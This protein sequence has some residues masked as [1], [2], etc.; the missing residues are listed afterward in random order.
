MELNN[1]RG[2][3]SQAA[4]ALT[5]W[6]LGASLLGMTL[7][8]TSAQAITITVRDATGAPFST[9][10]GG[11]RYTIEEDNTF[12]VVPDVTGLSGL[13]GD[14]TLSLGLHKSYMK[15][16]KVGRTTTNSVDWTP[17]DSTKR[18]FISVTPLNPEFTAAVPSGYTSSGAPIRPIGGAFQDVVVPLN[19]IPF[20]TAQISVL[21]FEDT[22]INGAP[23]APGSQERGLCGFEVQLFEAGGTYG[24]SG[25]RVGTD[26][27]GNWLGTEYGGGD[28]SNIVK[29]GSFQQFADANGVVRIKN[30]AP[31]KYTVY[32]V[33]PPDMPSRD[34]CNLGDAARTPIWVRGP[35]TAAQQLALQPGQ[36]VW[37]SSFELP[38][39]ASEGI[40]KKWHQTS[41][42]EGT[43]GVDAWVKSGEPTFF[44]EFGPPGHHVFIG[45]TRRFKD[46]AALTGSASVTGTVKSTHMSRPPTIRFHS[47]AP[48][49]AC[50]IGINAV[51]P[52]AGLGTGVYANACNPDGS[53]S[54]TNLVAGQRY[55]LVV[56]D[57]PLDNVIGNYEFTVPAGGGTVAL[58]DVPVFSWFSKL[59]GKVFYDTDSS[60]FP[61]E[62]SGAAKPGIPGSAVNIRFR[63]GS[64]YQ[65]TGTDDDG[66]W[67]FP[68]VFPFF[69]WLTAET[70][71]TRFKATGATI[72]AD[73]GGPVVDPAGTAAEPEGLWPAG[74]M[75]PQVIDGKN[76]RIFGGTDDPTAPSSANLLQTFQGFLGQTNIIHWGKREYDPRVPSDHGGI[77]GVVHY[78]TTR[79]ES[80]PR[81]TGAE[82][83][84]PGIPSVEIRLYKL[85][86]QNMVVSPTTGIGG[87]V[88]AF[89]VVASLG[90]S[91]TTRRYPPPSP[92]SSSF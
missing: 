51:N 14:P 46:T 57:E 58:G 29:Q 3:W 41:T 55:Q 80:D 15:V 70:D 69:N 4:K 66:N 89:C 44:K 90:F 62:A 19:R 91:D 59:A 8:S 1:V 9:D 24:A 76:Y 27:F 60:G 33:P 82:N 34:R 48:M 71:F 64:I 85:N 32:V 47:G 43:W 38:P 18:Y 72:I 22:T 81:F 61:F 39:K 88:V 73:N 28:P 37:N 5:R 49:T 13:S 7:A 63:D 68:E 11:F 52:A 17:P 86:N 23:D 21:V 53:F 25:G 65:S 16:V 35:L 6:L 40:Q 10:F 30:L 87:L 78:A 56:W 77:T 2:S 31:A 92:I 83:N 79:A 67:E 12:D 75:T 84:E 20:K 54:V 26:T 74:T 36:M 50:W 42:I 45:F